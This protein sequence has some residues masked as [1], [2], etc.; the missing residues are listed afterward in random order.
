VSGKCEAPV[1]QWVPASVWSNASG[2][3]NNYADYCT[4]FRTGE[5]K[6]E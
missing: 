5:V 4:L 3:G 2:V 6:D 1:P